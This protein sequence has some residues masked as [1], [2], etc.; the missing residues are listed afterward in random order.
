ME[1]IL[2]LQQD[3]KTLSILIIA[4]LS[5]VWGVTYIATKIAI[6]AIPV[7][8]LTGIR[9][10]VA[11]L[12]LLGLALVIEKP[13]NYRISTLIGQGIFGIGFFTGARGLMTLSLDFIPTGLVALVYSLIPIYVL[14]LNAFVGQFFINRQIIVGLLLGALGMV[15]VFHESLRHILSMYHVI[16]IGI[17]F[18]GALS[19]AGTSVWIS[20]KKHEALP[21]IFRS[22]IQL[23]FGA[24]GLWILSLINQ[25][26]LVWSAIDT[27]TIVAMLYLILFGSVSGFVAYSFAIKHLPVAKVTLYAYINPFVALFLGWLVLHEPI[28]VELLLSFSV[29]LLGVYLVNRGF[30]SGKN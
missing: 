24:A 9:E 29:T 12:I 25:E 26:S 6:K 1:K 15:S 7:F 22:A 30:R 28:S 8:M 18:M 21:P 13:R 16:G 2:R 3:K 17:A 19:W 10:L 27:Q 20:G 11:G 4:F 14:F 5:I 23:I